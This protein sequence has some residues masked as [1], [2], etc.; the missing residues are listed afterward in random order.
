MWNWPS[1]LCR[2]AN[3]SPT[4]IQGLS[5]AWSTL[6]GSAFASRRARTTST[7]MQ[8]AAMCRAVAPLLSFKF[9]DALPL[10]SA[11]TVLTSPASTMSIKAVRPSRPA[12]EGFARQPFGRL[13]LWNSPL[14]SCIT[15]TGV[16]LPP[17]MGEAYCWRST[18]ASMLYR[19]F[20]AMSWVKSEPNS[21]FSS[22]SITCSTF[23]LAAHWNLSPKMPSESK[24]SRRTSSPSTFCMK[25]A[26]RSGAH[27]PKGIR[28][29]SR[30]GSARAAKRRRIAFA[31]SPPCI[32]GGVLARTMRG[33]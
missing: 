9:T 26:K 22:R 5:P 8:L 32:V 15:P 2:C 21:L 11:F 25:A 6:C 14:I 18:V 24:C 17:A 3:S 33:V 1:S 29:L 16:R 12:P 20:E 31:T 23:S 19:L 4:S 27:R 7:C 10:R 13:P 30:C 28:P